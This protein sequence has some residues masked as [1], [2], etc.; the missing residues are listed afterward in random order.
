MVASLSPSAWIRH[1]TPAFDRSKCIIL[2]RRMTISCCVNTAVSVKPIPCI[3]RPLRHSHAVY[4]SHECHVEY[5]TL[6]AAATHQSKSVRVPRRL[7]IEPETD[8]RASRR[9]NNISQWPSTSNNTEVD[10][11]HIFFTQPNPS[12]QHKDPPNDRIRALKSWRD[13]CSLI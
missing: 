4:F 7:T 5:F 9:V 3:T 13:C 11:G 1:C 12:Y 8:P 6:F 2:S 10:M